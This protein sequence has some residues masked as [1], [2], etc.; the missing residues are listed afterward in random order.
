MLKELK[1]TRQIPGEPFRRWYT[2]NDNDLIVWLD[3]YRI[4][5]F[6][7]L[8][9]SS[10]GR[11]VITW[12]EGQRPTL[13]GLDEGE[14]R[15]A[16]P[17]MTPILIQHNKINLGKVLRHFQSISGELPSGLTELIEQRIMELKGSE[18]KGS[19]QNTERDGTKRAAR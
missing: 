15:P 1:S 17:K 8:A 14:G 16:R 13:A 11:I 7:L 4:T 18:S 19:E 2:D 6:Q 5:G 3:H 9:P 12:H 10:Y